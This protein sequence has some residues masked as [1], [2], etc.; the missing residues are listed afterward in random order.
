MTTMQLLNHNQIFWFYNQLS[1]HFLLLF[2]LITVLTIE[3]SVS[4][5]FDEVI[6]SNKA[7]QGHAKIVSNWISTELFSRFGLFL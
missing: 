5:Y 1:Y 2:E 4:D 7:L 3:R 6:K